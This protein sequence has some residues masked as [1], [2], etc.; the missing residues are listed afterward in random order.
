MQ[1][2]EQKIDINTLSTSTDTENK[3]N[4]VK[5]IIYVWDISGI[6][7]ANDRKKQ[8]PITPIHISYQILCKKIKPLCNAFNK[9]TQLTNDTIT[10]D[11]LW[12]ITVTISYRNRRGHCHPKKRLLNGTSTGGLNILS[13]A[14]ETF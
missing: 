14:S 10:H 6:G 12:N 3:M 13:F 8:L 1:Y 9:I 2:E 7:K 4:L 5:A 11:I